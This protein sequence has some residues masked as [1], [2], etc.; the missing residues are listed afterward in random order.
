MKRSCGY[1]FWADDIG[2]SDIMWCRKLKK[3]HD[4]MD[5]GCACFMEAFKIS[6]HHDWNCDHCEGIDC[7]FYDWEYMSC[8]M[9]LTPEQCSMCDGQ[10]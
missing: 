7:A 4:I 5:P 8:E 9:L 2:S 3:H 1:C 10:T 6:E